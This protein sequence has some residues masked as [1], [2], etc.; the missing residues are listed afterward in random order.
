MKNTNKVLQFLG[1]PYT[2]LLSVLLGLFLVSFPMG[3]FVVFDTEIGKDVNYE[4]PLSHLDLFSSAEFYQSDF[5]ISLGDAFVVLWLF[6]LIIFSIA[7]L[8]PKSNFLKSLSPIIS[9]GNFDSKFNYMIGVTKWFSIL[10]LVSAVI[11]FVQEG[12]G[13]SITPPTSTNDLTQFFYVSLAPL[14]EE[15]GFRIILLGIPLFALY[16]Q[17]SSI[18]YFFKCLW[19][20][21]KLKIYDYKKAI[22]LI[23]FI[24]VLFGFAHIA[25]VDSWSEGKFAQATAGGLILGWV[26]VRYGFI[27]C[28]LI[29][30][31]TNYF[32]FSYANFISQVNSIAIEDAFNHSLMSSIEILFLAAGIV[33]VVVLFANRFLKSDKHLE[34]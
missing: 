26:Y 22:L 9:F 10:I 4:L 21:T 31:A 1:I 25:F 16:S 24:A 13:I 2:A 34:V 3:I 27:V 6:Y 32:I 33:S 7:L 17:K 23:V 12:L 14:L 28:L 5:P 11:A 20:P 29:H 19:N 15:F 30:W 8:G 18:G